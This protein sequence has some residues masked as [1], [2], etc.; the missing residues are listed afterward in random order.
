MCLIV[1]QL[2]EELDHQPASVTLSRELR[3][4]LLPHGGL[5][6]RPAGARRRDPRQWIAVPCGESPGSR[7]RRRKSSPTWEPGS[8]VV[9][10]GDRGP[11]VLVPAAVCARLERVLVDAVAVARRQGV[12]VDPALLKWS[13]RS[14]PWRRIIVVRLS[15]RRWYQAMPLVSAGDD[16]GDDD[17]LTTAEAA[18]RL[19]C[20]VRNVRY[21]A[22]RHRLGREGAGPLAVRPGRR[23]RVPRRRS[24]KRECRSVSSACRSVRPRPPGLRSG[25]IGCSVRAL[26]SMLPPNGSPNGRRPLRITNAG[27]RSTRL[28]AGLGRRPVLRRRGRPML[29]PGRRSGPGRRRAL[30]RG[31]SVGRHEGRHRLRALNPPPGLVGQR[32][33]VSEPRVHR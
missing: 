6:G 10:L 24:W 27:G 7:P 19:A 9:I 29:R 3:V 22:A 23:R 12:R 25:R 28:I 8:D 5:A 26:P 21:L 33:A 11:V 2:A 30:H 13:L 4:C 15:C 14:P 32:P 18:G 1:L 31:R 17:W 20:S 16:L